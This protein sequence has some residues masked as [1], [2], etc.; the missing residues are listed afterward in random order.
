MAALES[1][2]GERTIALRERPSCPTQLRFFC[3]W[4][5]PY[6]Q[7]VWI[8][9]EYL[10][11]PY[12]YT[13]I[14]PYR[15]PA[16][17]ESL[18][19]SEKRERYPDFIAASPHG[20]VPALEYTVNINT[21]IQTHDNAPTKPVERVH[22]SLVCLEYVNERFAGGLLPAADDPAGRARARSWCRFV[23]ERILP[24]FYRLLMRPTAQEQDAEKTLLL[25]GLKQFGEAMS[26]EAAATSG[27]G[28]GNYTNG[29]TGT[30]TTGSP[31]T[32]TSGGGPFFLGGQFSMVDLA[33]IPWWRRFVAV[34]GAYRGFEVPEGPDPAFGRLHRW[35]A[36]CEA[37]PAV[38]AT[39]VDQQR[40]VA[41]YSGYANASATSDVARRIV[42]GA[43]GA[44]GGGGGGGG[45]SSSGS[46]NK[47]RL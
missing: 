1:W 3:S 31:P 40:L 14:S 10:G 2:R 17:K 7:R 36:A 35:A 22:D 47:A 41:D 26:P 30:T 18:S 11:V 39:I 46:G 13:E 4:F 21:A 34:A 24:H 9:L 5:C 45:G 38:G 32:T 42:G 20:L 27:G 8:S 19:L 33:L 23:D 12:Q 37:L 44:G 6:A 15:R 43:A 16:T 28:G 29:T 25:A